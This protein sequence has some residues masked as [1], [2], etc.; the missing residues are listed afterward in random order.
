MSAS[1]QLADIPSSYHLAGAARR[2]HDGNGERYFAILSPED[3]SH[4]GHIATHIASYRRNSACHTVEGCKGAHS[5]RCGPRRVPVWHSLV[6][7][8]IG[9]LWFALLFPLRPFPPLLQRRIS[10]LLQ[11]P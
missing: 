6:F 9:R 10:P 11:R 2:W 3:E 8:A 7:G 1:G 5:H 4:G